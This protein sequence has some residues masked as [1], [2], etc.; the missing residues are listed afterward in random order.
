MVLWAKI[1]AAHITRI[2]ATLNCSENCALSLVFNAP[3]PFPLPPGERV[4][5]PSLDGRG[6]G[7]VI[8]AAVLNAADYILVM[9]RQIYVIL[10]IYPCTMLGL[11][12]NR[13]PNIGSGGLPT[14]G[15][16]TTS[17]LRKDG[18]AA[19]RCKIIVSGVFYEKSLL[20]CVGV[21]RSSGRNFFSARAGSSANEHNHKH[22]EFRPAICTAPAV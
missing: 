9:S 21:G 2:T 8:L 1:G 16:V 20:Y 22:R 15:Q 18:S 6:K 7:R 17:R 10:D 4:L 19:A 12:C 11:F 3:S 13:L 5:S 14:V